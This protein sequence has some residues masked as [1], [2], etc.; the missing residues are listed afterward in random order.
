MLSQTFTL[1][2]AGT[3]FP[4]SVAEPAVATRYWECES[5]TGTTNIDYS[6]A[7]GHSASRP[8]ARGFK[9]A[10]AWR[11]ECEHGKAES[12]RILFSHKVCRCPDVPART[13]I[14]TLSKT[15]TP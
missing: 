10:P 1:V 15:S 7:S 12:C 5:T 13:V 4:C 2:A 9:P 14:P 3:S 6:D 11:H 8:G